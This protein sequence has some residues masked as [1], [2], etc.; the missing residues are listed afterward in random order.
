MWLECHDIASPGVFENFLKVQPVGNTA[1]KFIIEILRKDK[2]CNA[3]WGILETQSTVVEHALLFYCFGPT[4][5]I[6]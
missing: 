1:E 2:K 3:I 6:K 5:L 4:T